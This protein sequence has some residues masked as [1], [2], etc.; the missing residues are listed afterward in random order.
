MYLKQI[1]VGKADNMSD[2]KTES[3]NLVD[4]TI[5]NVGD[6]SDHG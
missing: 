4:E 1:G 2:I 6:G 5:Q 3:L